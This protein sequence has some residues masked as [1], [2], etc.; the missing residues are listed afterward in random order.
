MMTSSNGSILL[1]LCAGNSPV[2]G[3]FASQRPATQS[4]DVFIDLRRKKNTCVNNREAGDLRRHRA[5]Y[6]V[7]VVKKCKDIYI[8]S[9]KN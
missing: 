8:L 6:D 1:A 4:F 9:K 2:A 5:H 7:I 3:D